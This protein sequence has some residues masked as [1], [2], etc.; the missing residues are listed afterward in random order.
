MTTTNMDHF[1]TYDLPLAAYL[2]CCDY[3]LLDVR[4]EHSGRCVFVFPDRP[5]RPNDVGPSSMKA[6]PR[7]PS[8]M[9]KLPGC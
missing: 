7:R 1:E 9:R 2:R 3:P 8:S 6:A 5:S 4:R